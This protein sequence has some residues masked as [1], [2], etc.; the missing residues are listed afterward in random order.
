ML[1]SLHISNF[2]LIDELTID[3]AR[4]LNVLTGETGAGKS[5]ILDA[6]D[7]LLGGTV[8]V[9][10]VRSGTSRAIVQGTFT[11]PPHLLDWLQAND[12]VVAA[13]LI[14]TREISRTG[15]TI[16]SK[17]RVNGTIVSKQILNELREHL[18]EITGQG[19]TNQIAHQQR[20]LLDAYGGLEA[21]RLQVTHRF[22]ACQQAEKQLSQRQQQQ[23]DHAF[24]LETL[25]TEVQELESAGLEAADEL[26]TLE[27]EHQTL[28][29]VVDLQQQSY[30][31]YQLL[32]QNDSGESAA[33]DLLSKAENLL[34]GC[35]DIDPK[36]Q[37]LLDV[38]S[39]SLTQIIDVGRRINSYGDRLEADP[40]RLDE[41]EDRMRFL[42]HICRKYGC[43]LGELIDRLEKSQLELAGLTGKGESIEELQAI[44]DTCQAE[45]MQA[46]QKLTD[47]R[48]QTAQ[49]LQQQLVA[50]LKPLGMAKVQF[51]VDIQPQTPTS[52]GADNVYFLFSPNP[53]E[54]LQSLAATASGG[55][56]SRFL[57]ALKACF[58]AITPTGTLIFDEIDTGVSGKITQSIA[59]KLQQLAIDRQVLCVTHQPI[60]AAMADVHFQ[61][62]K[63]GVGKKAQER[64]V[65]KIERL[66]PQ[67][68]REE[69]AQLAGGH[70]AADSIAFADSL[71]SQATPN[72]PLEKLQEGSSSKK[73]HR[74][75]KM[76]Q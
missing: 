32:Y 12:I 19:Q 45:L 27:Q 41:I 10:L 59:D 35:V 39:D 9:R 61:V 20:Q 36:L 23:A 52:N 44:L 50:E 55:E 30:Q 72:S 48:Q 66:E 40:K 29:H 70:S 67:G 3:F 15:G 2:A 69:I 13:N 63:E 11:S 24:R 51:L 49:K 75:A 58:S 62:R 37:M 56:M 28:N 31:I 14:C 43:N 34:V 60:M 8:S 71:I 64:T 73:S 53:G 76:A 7:A 46:C 42:K 16:R 33:A 57:L 26:V 21:D 74:R 22:Q 17:L 18:V 6:I 47:Q 5:I 25:R 65:V 4:G 38:V 1:L 68:R 54:P